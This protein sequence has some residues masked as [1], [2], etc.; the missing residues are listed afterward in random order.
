MTADAIPVTTQLWALRSR[1]QPDDL[2]VLPLKTTSQIAIGKA[3]GGS[4]SAKTPIPTTDTSYKSPG[5]EAMFHE[6]PFVKTCC[7]PLARP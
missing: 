7:S 1:I 2:V 3:S 5:Y 6:P 4:C